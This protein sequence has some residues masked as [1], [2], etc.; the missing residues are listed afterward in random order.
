MK[1]PQEVWFL[2]QCNK[3]CLKIENWNLHWT[4]L[5]RNATGFSMHTFSHEIQ[6]MQS[7]LFFITKMTIYY[8]NCSHLCFSAFFK[9]FLAIIIYLKQCNTLWNKHE[10]A[11]SWCRIWINTKK[12]FWRAKNVHIQ[13]KSKMGDSSQ[14]QLWFRLWLW[15][16]VLTPNPTPVGKKVD[17]DSNSDSSYFDSDSGSDYDSRYNSKLFYPLTLTQILTPVV[18]K[19][20]L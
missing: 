18:K 14:S 16:S 1:M 13:T 15:A 6:N 4:H 17:S 2:W 12:L 20:W 8:L 10:Y 9:K 11:K 7:A 3:L 19:C 5:H